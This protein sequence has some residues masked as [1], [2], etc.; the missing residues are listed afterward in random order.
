MLLHLSIVIRVRWPPF[1]QRKGVFSLIVRG[2]TSTVVNGVPCTA[3]KKK[4]VFHAQLT[5]HVT[6]WKTDDSQMTFHVA[7]NLC[8]NLNPIKKRISRIRLLCLFVASGARMI[9]LFNRAPSHVFFTRA[10]CADD[11]FFKKNYPAST[12]LIGIDKTVILSALREL[13]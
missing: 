11:F 10:A 5:I 9:K 13:K 8:K 7:Y 6:K 1:I 2:G 4:M 3:S 12:S